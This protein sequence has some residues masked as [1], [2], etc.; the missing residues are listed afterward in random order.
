M[1]HLEQKL[2]GKYHMYQAN[3]QNSQAREIHDFPYLDRIRTWEMQG[4][5][6]EDITP[7]RLAK[8][9]SHPINL[10]DTMYG[11]QPEKSTQI[12]ERFVKE[13]LEEIKDRFSLYGQIPLNKLKITSARRA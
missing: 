1:I 11:T 7:M 3:G 6:L 9:Q 10:A 8:P 2:I 13:A 4:Q 12:D 5:L